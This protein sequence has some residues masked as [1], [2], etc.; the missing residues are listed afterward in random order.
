M[1][2]E[3]ELELENEHLAKRHPSVTAER[4]AEAIETLEADGFCLACGEEASGV[5]PDACRYEC[6]GCGAEQV[7]GAEEIL[8]RIAA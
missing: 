2:R 4:V 7:Y 5:E 1:T 3:Q 6:E 8:L